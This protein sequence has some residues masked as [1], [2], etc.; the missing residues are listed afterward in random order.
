MGR[1]FLAISRSWVD[2]ASTSMRGRGVALHD[3]LVLRGLSLADFPI[4]MHGLIPGRYILTAFHLLA[5]CGLVR[6]SRLAGALAEDVELIHRSGWLAEEHRGDGANVTGVLWPFPG[7]I[8]CHLCPFD[9]WRTEIVSAGNGG[10][11]FFWKLSRHPLR[12]LFLLLLYCEIISTA[13]VWPCVERERGGNLVAES[14][15]H[16]AREMYLY[17]C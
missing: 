11:A 8:S 17:F 4:A 12:L 3:L 6:M 16:L 13:S 2:L 14:S 10:V 15:P 5:N 7:A 1:S 9:S